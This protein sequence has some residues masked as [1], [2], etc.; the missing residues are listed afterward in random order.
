MKYGKHICLLA[1]CLIVALPFC[2]AK[3]AKKAKKQKTESVVMTKL[4]NSI[5]YS[6]G[7]LIFWND[8][9]EETKE[10]TTLENYR[11]S[12]ELFNNHNI[13][14]DE[15]DEY[16]IRGF[17]QVS[18]QNFEAVKFEGLGGTLTYFNDGI[19]T[20]T[21]PVKAVNEMLKINGIVQIEMSQRVMLPKPGIRK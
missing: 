19:Y 12:N 1:L 4:P 5:S 11:P 21:L 13:F 15:K 6:K 3:R 9:V 18:M 20:F 8:F 10:L 17:L 14:I 7:F 2:E 16:C